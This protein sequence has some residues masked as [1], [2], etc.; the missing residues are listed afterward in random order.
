MVAGN[1]KDSIF[2]NTLLVHLSALSIP[3]LVPY[4]PSCPLAKLAVSLMPDLEDLENT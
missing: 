1:G 3:S 4:A 2:T